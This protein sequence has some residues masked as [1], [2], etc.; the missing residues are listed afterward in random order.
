MAK[1]VIVDQDD[2]LWNYIAVHAISYEKMMSAVYG[3]NNFNFSKGPG[4]GST[5]REIILEAL[6]E[7][8][9]KEEDITS[10]FT[11]SEM[12]MAGIVREELPRNNCIGVF[13]GATE[14][15]SLAAKKGLVLATGTGTSRVI[16]EEI[17][18]FTD[19][20][21][22]FKTGAFG[23]DGNN[24]TDVFAKAV[25]RAKDLDSIDKVYV[26]GDAIKDIT[27]AKEIGAKMLAM[28]TGL[29]RNKL[30]DYRADVIYD[31]MLDYKR[32]VDY[33]LKN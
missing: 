24:R 2:T 17:L 4:V 1:L 28:K 13:K 32:M 27:S 14:F 25:E 26:V 30:I 6:K 16:S 33:I 19:L 3:V 15:L 9:L 18:R 5:T 8:R 22:Y 21:K 31:S 23:D 7:N 29:H 20:Y 10:R 11:Q 12:L